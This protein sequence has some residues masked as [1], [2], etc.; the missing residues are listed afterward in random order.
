M[1]VLW[2]ELVDIVIDSS[3]IQK[4]RFPTLLNYSIELQ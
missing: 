1:F 2:A 4:K 3:V